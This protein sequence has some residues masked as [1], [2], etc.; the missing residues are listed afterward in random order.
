V[1]HRLKRV[2]CDPAAHFDVDGRNPALVAGLR[3]VLESRALKQGDQYGLLARALVQGGLARAHPLGDGPVHLRCDHIVAELDRYRARAIGER[4]LH[5]RALANIG[6]LL[7]LVAQRRD[8]GVEAGVLLR[9]ELVSEPG[10]DHSNLILP[11]A[12][13]GARP[14]FCGSP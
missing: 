2:T 6:L 8:A 9:R 13:V 14:S 4:V 12:R 10:G 11:W 3:A 7:L 1:Q 5:Q